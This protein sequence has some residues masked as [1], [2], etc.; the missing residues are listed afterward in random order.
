MLVRLTSST[1]GEIIMFAEHA[2]ALFEWIGKETTARGV[3]M[4]ALRSLGVVAQ[5]TDVP[6]IL[7]ETYYPNMVAHERYAV[8]QLRQKRLYET[9]VDDSFKL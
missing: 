2:H 1:S 8:A 5:L 9:L 6:L 3:A 4:L 7:A